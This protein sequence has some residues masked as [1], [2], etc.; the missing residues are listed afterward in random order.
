[1]TSKVMNNVHLVDDSIR[2]EVIFVEGPVK[3]HGGYV[4]SGDEGA[5]AGTLLQN[6][7]VTII[8]LRR[9]MRGQT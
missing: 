2:R 7:S 6:N 4:A 5:D 3:T 1:M 8:N 9:M